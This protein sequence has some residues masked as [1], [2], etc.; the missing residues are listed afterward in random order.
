AKLSSGSRIVKAS[1]DA[2]S[3]AVGTKLRADVTALKQAATNASQASS[4]LQVADGAMSRIA[5][6]LIR[7]KSLATQAQ[8][9]V[10]SDTERGYLDQE[11]GAMEEQIDFIVK[12]TRFNDVSIISG[13]MG[14]NFTTG[15]GVGVSTGV[16]VRATG[17]LTDGDTFELSSVAATGLVTLT[18]TVTNE[19][20]TKN[21]GA[22]TLTAN[23][24]GTIAFEALGIS[25]DYDGVDLS[26]DLDAAPNTVTVVHGPDGQGAATFQVGVDAVSDVVTVNL[27]SSD[28]AALDVDGLSIATTA[29]AIAASTALDDAIK[30]V[31]A[32]RATLG[33]A[34]SRIE[35]IG[36]NIAT[37]MENLDA[38][39]S[40]LMDVDVAEE[41][42]KFTTNQVMTQAATAM[43]AQ[44]NQL[45]QNL[46]RLLQ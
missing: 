28:A 1:D 27:K 44:A 26:A 39:R 24:S 21:L 30:T 15:A 11:F 31:N 23:F 4:L 6:A 29:G 12:S 36:E 19:V 13:A 33:A 22:G 3:L 45:P 41:M 20:Q 35:K 43:L 7:M 38:A 32:E 42:T 8:S 37:T 18:N 10:L 46:M 5:D 9:T 2:A 25:F 40:I 16:T 34:M 17:G 14:T